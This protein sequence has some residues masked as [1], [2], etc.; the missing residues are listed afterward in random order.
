M[1]AENS[2]KNK[3]LKRNARILRNIRYSVQVLVLLLFL[4]LLLGTQQGATTILPHDF[5]FRLDPLA[6]I[7]AMLASRSWLAPMALGGIILLL[8][9]AVGRVW[10][11]WLCPLGTLLDWTPAR[12]IRQNRIDI[13]S[14]WRYV[15]DFFLFAILFSALYGSLT[16]LILDPVTLLFR[17][18][19]SAILPALD[20]V[21]LRIE[22]WLYRFELIQPAVEWF[23]SVIRGTIFTGQSFFIPNLILAAVFIGVLAFNMVR[24]RFWCR[25]LCP[26]GALLGLISRISFFR[27]S[28][29]NVKCTNCQHCTFVCPT[30]AINLD[31]EIAVDSSEC[32]QCHDCGAVCPTQAISFRKQL[33]LALPQRPRKPVTPTRSRPHDLSR[34]QFLTSIGAAAVGSTLLR[35]VPILNKSEPQLVRPPGTS[36]DKLTSKCIRCGECVKVCPT[37]SIQP[38]FSD[39][40]WKGIWT[41]R[42]VM[43]SGYCDYSC[44]L[45]GQVCPT[46]A[47]TELPI[48]EKRLTI[49][50]AAS[51]D[52][53]SCIPWSQGRS[54]IVC[55]ELCPI[56]QKA[57][58]LDR[59]IVTNS[60]GGTTTVLRP[61]VQ[62]D[63]CIGCGTCEYMCPIEGVA[64]I[65]VFPVDS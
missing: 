50:G 42:L 21:V 3:K 47:I 58:K 38:S 23:D 9:L 63:L 5:F 51:I 33:N 55:E 26:L 56:P 14:Y 22:M 37:G 18:I 7:S 43:R 11:S 24:P 41:P 65:R 2:K 19:S 1:A 34:R 53:N 57:I 16:L 62:Q 48:V 45:C 6:G 27:Y 44:N 54:C 64:A 12:R 29:D 49:I 61:T 52:R 28:Q 46:G 39:D 59:A 17:S 13:P 60:D 25:Y 10:C 31:K 15:K 32:I 36:E 20:F 35:M 40:D 4:Y 30:G 8:T